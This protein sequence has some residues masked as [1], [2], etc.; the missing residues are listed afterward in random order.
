MNIMSNHC[1]C[2]A[3]FYSLQKVCLTFFEV[4][5]FFFTSHYPF[6]SLSLFYFNFKRKLSFLCVFDNNFFIVFLSFT[7][8]YEVIMSNH[9]YFSINFFLWKKA[10]SSLIQQ[11]SF[12]KVQS[13]GY[14]MKLDFLTAWLGYVAIL[15]DRDTDLRIENIR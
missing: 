12:F 11:L 4:T 13:S 14:A 2:S 8:G 3:N 5:F 15:K 10:C 1:I 7:A 9:G 6:V